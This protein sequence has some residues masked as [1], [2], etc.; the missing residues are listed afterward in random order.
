MSFLAP[1]RVSWRVCCVPSRVL[2]CSHAFLACS[3]VFSRVLPPPV[4]RSPACCCMLSRVRLRVA[5][6]RD[7]LGFPTRSCVLSHVGRVFAR[8]LVLPV[9]FTDPCY[10]MLPRVSQTPGVSWRVLTCPRMLAVCFYVF[11]SSLSHGLMRVVA[12]RHACGHVLSCVATCR[13][14]LCFFLTRSYVSSRV[15][16]V[17]S[18]LLRPL[19]PAATRVAAC[20]PMSQLAALPGALS[21]LF[22]VIPRVFA[23]SP[24]SSCTRSRVSSYVITRA[25][26][27]GR[28][29]PRVATCCHS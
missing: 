11:P 21:R 23:C 15:G 12:C 20:C 5:A 25:V 4:A 24:A 1:P 18:R 17:F 28:V 26:T 22:H 14:I 8:V 19:I 27:C 2:A 16:R 3:H 10:R 13:N 9:A 6:S 29:L 7:V